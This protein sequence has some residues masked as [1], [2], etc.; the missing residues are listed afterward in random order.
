M[1]AAAVSPDC[2]ERSEAFAETR[3]YEWLTAY[4]A[5]YGFILRWPEERQSATGMVYAPWHWR[6]VGAENAR[7]IR[8]SGLSLEEFLA[9]ERAKQ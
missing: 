9:L 5:D 1:C 6:Y 3:A 4:A 7:A 8:E 2:T